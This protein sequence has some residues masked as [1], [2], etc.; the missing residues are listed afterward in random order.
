MVVLILILLTM[1]LYANVDDGSCVPFTQGCMN[2]NYIEFNA[3]A[4]IDDGS[5]ATPCNLWMYY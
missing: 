3:L 1:M 5:C 4:N 2:P